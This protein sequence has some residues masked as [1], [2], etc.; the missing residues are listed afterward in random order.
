MN[1]KFIRLDNA[2]ENKAFKEQSNGKDW[3]L[4]LTFEF[5]GPDTL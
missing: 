2:R 1:V 4:N 5:T 3:R